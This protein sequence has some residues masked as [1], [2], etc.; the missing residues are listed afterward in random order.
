MSVLCATTSNRPPGSAATSVGECRPGPG[1]P[2]RR[3]PRRRE[4]VL[5]R[6]GDEPVG[7][8]RVRGPQLAEGAALGD[9]EVQLAQPR[10]DPGGQP[11]Q[12]RGG[13]GGGP[14]RRRSTSR[15][16]WST[17]GP[18]AHRPAPRPATRRR[19]RAAMSLRPVYRFG[20]CHAVRP[21]RA[22]HHDGA[23]SSCARL[24]RAGQRR[25]RCS[26]A[27]PVRRRSAS[28]AAANRSTAAGPRRGPPGRGRTI[29]ARWPASDRR[30]PRR[31]RHPERGL[32]VGRAGSEL[33][34]STSARSW[35]QYRAAGGAAGESTAGRS[36]S[37][38]SG[39]SEAKQSRST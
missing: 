23:W 7:Q 4:V 34:P 30:R 18:A 36:T 22:R 19:R 3:V 29:R 12:R 5:G 37:A 32:G 17:P 20:E 13:R 11:G 28:Y 26:R 31:A 14:A 25:R 10:V 24:R 33:R 2:R 27:R 21:C 15:P 38:P 35:F 6:V 16:G 8:R 1:P 9:P 39:V